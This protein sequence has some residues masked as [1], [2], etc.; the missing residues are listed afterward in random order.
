MLPSQSNFD[1]R[2]DVNKL[3]LPHAFDR[4]RFSGCMAFSIFRLLVCL[5]AV[6]VVLVI[7]NFHI[8][9]NS[10]RH[11]LPE[12]MVFIKLAWLKLWFRL[13]QLLKGSPS[14]LKSTKMCSSNLQQYHRS[15]MLPSVML[16]T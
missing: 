5:R 16:P 1:L 4:F 9:R 8:S 7:Y 2:L 13:P 15:L 11:A 12:A 3:F 14:S 10:L 6:P